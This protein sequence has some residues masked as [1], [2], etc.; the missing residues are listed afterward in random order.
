M[1]A[2]WL[3]AGLLVS[4]A[5]ASQQDI[6]RWVDKDG[7]VHYSDQPG[8]RNAERI[9]LVN[10]SNTYEPDE[11]IGDGAGLALEPPESG[12]YESLAIVSP[13]PDQ[14][15]FGADASVAVTAEVGGTLQPDHTL[16]F[17]VNGARTPAADGQ[18]I[19]LTGLERGTHFLRATILDQNGNPVIS[20]QQIT[21]HV[22][23]PSIQ[24]PQNRTLP[25]NPRPPTQPTPQPQP[26]PAATTG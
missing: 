26:R 15:F 24:N 12:R 22:R 3:T 19:V 2:L 11:S 7:V 18:S 16:V 20:S 25:T 23:Q 8:D 5:A 1:R 17:F 14:S 6:Y 10:P 4:L 21:F 9:E 13:T